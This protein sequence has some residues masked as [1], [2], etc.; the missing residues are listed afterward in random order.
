MEYLEGFQTLKS[1]MVGLSGKMEVG[2][3]PRTRRQKRRH[4]A[5]ESDLEKMFYQI[6]TDV[7]KMHESGLIHGD[8]TSSNIMVKIG[9]PRPIFIDFGLSY[10]RQGY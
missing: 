3:Q 2:S 1:A 8:L 5:Q 6:G 9:D 7:A 4:L 10:I